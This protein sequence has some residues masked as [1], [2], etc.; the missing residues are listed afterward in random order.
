MLLIFILALQGFLGSV[1]ATCFAQTY[2]AT[3]DFSSSANPNGV[4]S[5]GQTTTL[6]AL[7]LY[8]ASRTIPFVGPSGKEWYPAPEADTDRPDVVYWIPGAPQLTLSA[9]PA[10][11][12]SVV[13]WTAPADG[14][15]SVNTTFSGFWPDSVVDGDVHVLVNNRHLFDS[16][17]GPQG[18]AP[19]SY[20]GQITVSQGD[21]VDFVLGFGANGTNSRDRAILTARISATQG[22]ILSTAS[23]DNQ[24]GT[25]LKALPQSL[26]VQVTDQSGNPPTT[27]CGHYFLGHP[28]THR[29]PDP[30]RP[31]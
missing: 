29:N 31:F 21:T 1:P 3:A 25:V 12:W 23:G 18:I 8:N 13:R 24:T 30:C 2:D 27:Q 10:G 5:Y 17:I 7:V 6:G 16:N 11:E 14:T 19:A 4:W 9:G 22:S 26:V 15:Y 28:R 20:S